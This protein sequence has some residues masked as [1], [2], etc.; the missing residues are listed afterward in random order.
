MTLE[1]GISTDDK[2]RINKSYTM[3]YSYNGVLKEPTSVINPVILVYAPLD[4]LTGCNYVY[5]PIFRRFYYI[6]E[7]KSATN[8]TCTIS[9]H[10]D[11]LMS[12]KDDIYACTG[13]VDRQQDIVNYMLPD[14]QKIKQVNPAISTVP[15]T[16]PEEASGFTYCLITTKA[17]SS[18]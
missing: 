6:S 15:F 16:T 13:Y 1:I 3:Q 14:P 9:C 10:V 5:I 2:N 17:V 7:M 8:D 4:M 12:F 18:E 11:V